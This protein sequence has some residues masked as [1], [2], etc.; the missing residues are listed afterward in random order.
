MEITVLDQLLQDAFQPQGVGKL[1]SAEERDRFAVLGYHLVRQAIPRE[2]AAKTVDRVWAEIARE[3]QRFCFCWCCCCLTFCFHC[4]YIHTYRT[5]GEL[6]V[7]R[8]QTWERQ[9]VMNKRRIRSDSCHSSAKLKS[10]LDDVLGP[11]RWGMEPDLGWQPIRLPTNRWTPATSDGK[12]S[13]AVPVTPHN[14]TQLAL[15]RDVVQTPPVLPKPGYYCADVLD[16][17]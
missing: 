9:N 3:D 11:D 17:H 15:R 7:T 2:T 14:S 10:A 8:D 4:V 16:G 6:G 13:R 5:Y 12:G 1:L